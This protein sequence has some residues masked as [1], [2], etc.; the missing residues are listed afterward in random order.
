M[1]AEMARVR[2]IKPGFFTNEV[3]GKMHPLAR[4][5]F[6]GLWVIA[7]REGR[8]E[9]RPER[10]RRE[11][12]GYDDDANAHELLA[13]LLKAGF[14]H[15]YTVNGVKFIQVCAWSKHQHPHR[16]E[17][18]S[19][20]PPCAENCACRAE[21]PDLFPSLDGSR[22]GE[23]QDKDMSGT[24]EG[25]DK[26]G[27]RT[28]QGTGQPGGLR[29]TVYGIRNKSN[30]TRGRAPLAAAEVSTLIRQWER[31]RGK[32]ARGVTASQGQV[33]ALAEMAVTE[34]EL[35]RAYDAAVADR[36][37]TADITPV[38]AGF[39][40]AFVS[41]LRRPTP[42]REDNAWKRT[43]NGIERKA[44]ELGIVCPPGR[45][46]DWLREKCESVLREREGVHA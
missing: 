8:L 7:D 3:L 4:L 43:P 21:S 17:V 20:I 33:I 5:L 1:G 27:S 2:M 13:A 46:Y 16:K 34:D 31:E 30:G 35:R 38:N 29:N 26:D 11:L 14:I 28:D 36:E 15:R 32:A 10:I 23:G 44:S 12:L 25:Q 39:V 41:K 22:T 18:K 19:D 24:V 42:K 45:N 37:A 9:D 40:A 6:A